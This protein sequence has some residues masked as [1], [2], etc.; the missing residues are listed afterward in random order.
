MSMNKQSLTQM[1]C[2][3]SNY[4]PERKNLVL[5]ENQLIIQLLGKVLFTFERAI[6]KC[7][8]AYHMSK[9]ENCGKNVYIGRHCAFTPKNISVGN[10]VFIGSG[11]VFQSVHGKIVIGNHVMF[12][13]CVHIH[14]GNHKTSSIGIYMDE[15]TKLPG[16]DGI[17]CIEDDVWIGQ[18]Q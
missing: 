15:V 7:I 16:S 1:V 2:N 17:V 3:A 12:G 5:G 11:A 9:F 6:S 4:K 10:N 14:G 8:N 18:M 13:P